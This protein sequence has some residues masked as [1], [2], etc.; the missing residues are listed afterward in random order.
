MQ[1]LNITEIKTLLE[2]SPFELFMAKL[3][4]ALETSL[5][6]KSASLKDNEIQQIQT[7]FEETVDK[8]LSAEHEMKQALVLVAV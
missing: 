4:L 8:F 7:L 6:E 2:S 5:Q 1:H 3:K